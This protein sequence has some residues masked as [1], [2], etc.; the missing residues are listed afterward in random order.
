MCF[1]NMLR[2]S[3][4]TSLEI[5]EIESSLVYGVI[6][7]ADEAILNMKLIASQNGNW[8]LSEDELILLKEYR[9]VCEK[10][11]KARTK[12]II[13]NDLLKRVLALEPYYKF[14]FSD[15]LQPLVENGI[16]I[17]QEEI[18]DDNSKRVLA[19]D[20]VDLIKKEELEILHLRNPEI[21]N[22]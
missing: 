13:D 15:K 8:T 21:S 9:A 7:Q 10:A 19:K 17:N 5:E 14:Y 6:S 22:G 11:A 12:A 18:N 20:I 2:N 1:V 4:L 16:I 3:L